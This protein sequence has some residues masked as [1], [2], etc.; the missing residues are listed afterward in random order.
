MV[1]AN[2]GCYSPVFLRELGCLVRS[3]VGGFESGRWRA[4]GRVD[5]RV[6]SWGGWS[7]RWTEGPDDVTEGEMDGRTGQEK[8]G[9]GID[10]RRRHQPRIRD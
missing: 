6:G 4:V 9:Q 7:L 1:R 5:G 10:R 3:Y 8:S 2:D